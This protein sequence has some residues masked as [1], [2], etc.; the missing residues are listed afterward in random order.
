MW[1]AFGD[2]SNPAVLVN[3]E[4]RFNNMKTLAWQGK[5][6]VSDETWDANNWFDDSKELGTLRAVQAMSAI[7][8]G[9]SLF[10]YLNLDT[11]NINFADILNTQYTIFTQY[12]SAILAHTAL[13]INSADMFAEFVYSALIP[14]VEFA[15]VWIVSRINGMIELWQ[16]QQ[17][18]PSTAARAA[19]IAAVLTDLQS[20]L[21]L[22]NDNVFINTSRLS[23][24]LPP[25]PSPTR[26]VHIAAE[27]KVRV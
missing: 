25:A 26:R 17:N 8:D 12:D 23:F 11:I 3:A 16:D 9:I 21:A 4:A 15:Q 1:T 24:R 14:Q 6:L 22:A 7:R 5:A 10:T 19:Q 18:M 27:F 2:D 13:T 20:L